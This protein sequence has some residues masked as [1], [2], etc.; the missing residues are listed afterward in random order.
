MEVPEG[1]IERGVD[2]LVGARLNDLGKRQWEATRQQMIRSYGDYPGKDDPNA[3]QPEFTP[4]VPAYN[5]F[6]NT[7]TE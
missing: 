5:P 1:T 6:T 4:G 7:W 2:G 3:P